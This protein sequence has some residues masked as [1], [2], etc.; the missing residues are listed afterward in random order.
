MAANKNLDGSAKQATEEPQEPHAGDPG[1]QAENAPLE[2]VATQQQEPYSVFTTRQKK[3][4]VICASIAA[5]FSPLSANIYFPALNTLAD[6]LH[7]STSLINLTVT[8]YLA[9][10]LH[11]NMDEQLLTIASPSNAI[12]QGIAPTFIGSFSDTAGRRPAYIICFTIYLAANIGLALQN[13]YS[14]LLVLRMLQSSGSSGTVAIA[15]AVAADIV[16]SAERG[17][18][19]GYTVMPAMIAPCVAPVIG[20]LL[21]QYC[22]WKWIFWF[23]VIFGAAFF[24]L[25]MFL[26]PE[27]CRTVVG[28]GTLEP[29]VWN[30]SLVSLVQRRRARKRKEKEG[31]DEELGRTVANASTAARPKAKFNWPN[32]MDVL[33]IIFDRVNFVILFCVALLFA[34]YYAVTASIP[35]RFAENYGYSVI[36]ISLIFIPLGVGSLISAFTIG[37]MMDWNY[38]R[39]ALKLGLSVEKGKKSQQHDMSKFPMERARLEIAMPLLYLGAA[40]TVAYGWC[41][42]ARTHV[43]GPIILL[44]VLGYALVAGFQSLS[45]LI[46]DLNRSKPATA[47]AA[48]NLVRCLFGAG[49][50][51]VVNPLTEAIGYGWTCVIAAGIWVAFTPLLWVLMKYGPEWRRRKAERTQLKEEKKQAQTEADRDDA[52]KKRMPGMMN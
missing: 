52:V 27:T 11:F 38:R 32:P 41:V 47:S 30:M 4:I 24:V 21:D 2:Q 3:S 10:Y 25:L 9:N 49:A 17:S 18:Y 15:S 29:P 31:K 33:R 22:G 16:T 51:A 44:L 43:S 48:N 6:D 19:V 42:Q 28:N 1:E 20:G 5:L 40:I 8:T 46:V 14:A 12:F 45:V 39:H 35:A 26:M 23:L 13:H 37:K 34:A 36:D 50:S 7:V